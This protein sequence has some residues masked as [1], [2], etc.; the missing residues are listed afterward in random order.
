MTVT[1][2]RHVDLVAVAA[3]AR[4]DVL[5]RGAGCRRDAAEDQQRGVHG[6]GQPL[7]EARG[8]RSRPRASARRRRWCGRS[9]S[10]RGRRASRR[11]P[12]GR[13]PGSGASG[14]QPCSRAIGCPS[15]S[16]TRSIRHASPERPRSS[17]AT[18]SAG[19]RSRSMPSEPRG[20]RQP[21]APHVLAERRQVQHALQPGPGH[22][23]A[24]AVDLVEQAVGDQAVDRLADRG[25]R[26]AVGRHQLALG[27]DGGVGTELADGQVGQHVGQLGVLGPRPVG[28][29]GWWTASCSRRPLLSTECRPELV[30]SGPYQLRAWLRRAEVSR[31][32]DDAPP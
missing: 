28:D 22:E 13:G 7:G 24:L 25:P 20:R 26:D 15:A 1:T 17:A 10:R 3:V 31:S 21:A 2:Q 32:R 23:R 5:Q 16:R 30:R 19:G 18:T 29:D 8:R 14:Y 27:G 6:C 12:G 4:D 9:A 11:G